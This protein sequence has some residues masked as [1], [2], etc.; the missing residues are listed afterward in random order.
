MINISKIE[1]FKIFNDDVFKIIPQLPHKSIDLIV[2]DPPYG[3]NTEYGRI[4]KKTIA[5]NRS[6]TI[7]NKFLL[8]IYSKLKD[9]AVIYLFTNHK[10]MCDIR[11]YAVNICAYKYINTIILSKVRIGLG[12]KFRN[13]YEVILV[14]EKGGNKKPVYNNKDF[15]NIIKMG[16]V[17]HDAESHPHEKTKDVFRKIIN[18]S[19]NKGDVIFDGFLGTGNNVLAAI[20]EGR[21]I[22][23]CEI[24]KKWYDVIMKKVNN[25]LT[26]TKLF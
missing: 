12:N 22:I 14:F 10:F 19:S 25:E 6:Y 7:N 20:E 23:G 1:Q 15:S 13:K 9:N 3:D 26:Q 16:N 21:K 24:E 5:N 2:T 17:V 18:H 4:H 8:D 11:S